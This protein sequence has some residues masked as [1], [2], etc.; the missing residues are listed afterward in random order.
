MVKENLFFLF[1]NDGKHKDN[2]ILAGPNEG[3][4]LRKMVWI[5]IK[6]HIMIKFN[7]SPYDKSKTEYFKNRE[8]FY[9]RV[10]YA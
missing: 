5:P 7:Y 2:W 4:H 8:Y 10:K 1:Y 9:N 6:R 3:N